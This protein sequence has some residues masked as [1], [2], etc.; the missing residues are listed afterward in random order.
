MSKMMNFIVSFFIKRTKLLA[1]GEA[2]VYMR[3]SAA[4][5]RIDLGI[6]RS[7]L[8]KQWDSHAGI[9]KG[10]SRN[11]KILNKYLQNLKLQVTNISNDLS[12][13]HTMV[14]AKMIRNEYLGVESE[15]RSILHIHNEYNKNIYDL[16]G[17][18]YVQGTYYRYKTSLKHLSN[19]IRNVMKE[20][21]FHIKDIDHD[22]VTNMTLF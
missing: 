18:D 5:Q 4:G 20:K 3:I 17:I 10:T 15:E 1:N 11:S 16:I 13:R 14:T 6:N 7:L 21:D 8:S 19:Y 12:L 2:P 9:A 22:F